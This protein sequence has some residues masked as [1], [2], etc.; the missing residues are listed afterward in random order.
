MVRRCIKKDS[1]L[2]KEAKLRDAANVIIYKW[3]EGITLDPI[4][5]SVEK[6]TAKNI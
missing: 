6:A 2:A 4:E 5:A 3:A 1:S